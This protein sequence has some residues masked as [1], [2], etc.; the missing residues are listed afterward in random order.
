MKYHQLAAI[1][2]VARAG[3]I[4]AAAK[5]LGVT[6][7]SVTKALRELEAEAGEALVIRSA[8]GATMTEAGRQLSLRAQLIVAQM[9]AAQGV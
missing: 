9:Q 1:D 3:G 6:Q 4:R 8:Q 7:G 2:A 5:S